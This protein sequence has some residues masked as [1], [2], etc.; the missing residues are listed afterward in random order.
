[1]KTCVVIP[2]YNEAHQIATLVEQLKNQGLEVVVVDDGSFDDTPSIAL[3]NGATV[4]KNGCNL[5]KGVA[6]NRGF[7]YALHH[8]FDAVI[9]MDG[10]GQHDPADVPCFMR[11]AQHSSSGVLI[12]NRMHKAKDMP[13]PRLLANKH[14]SWFISLVARQD[15]PDSQCGFRLIKKEVL[16]KLELCSRNFEIETELILLASRLGYRIEAVPI[17][18][19]YNG[20]KSRIRPLLD[21]MR[22][23]RFMINYGLRKGKKNNGRGA[24]A[25]A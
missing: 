12:G 9:T 20:H 16:E 13:W 23:V 17:T 6:L 24:A 19:V 22:F 25:G 14:M 11:L 3:Y 18:T 5:G 2:T 21:T 7:T 15:I 10:D 8:N 4:L 1:M